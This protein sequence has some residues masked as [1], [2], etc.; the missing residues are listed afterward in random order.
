MSDPGPTIASTNP[1]NTSDSVQTGTIIR[2]VIFHVG[3]VSVSVWFSARNVDMEIKLEV[4]DCKK[5]PPAWLL[6]SKLCM[7]K[8]TH[9]P[10]SDELHQ[11][12]LRSCITSFYTAFCV[13]E[14]G[15]QADALLG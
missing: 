4:R 2:G 7:P 13:E 14:A 15:R 3:E 12:L 6:L 10:P 5:F 9:S 8:R 1:T 11:M